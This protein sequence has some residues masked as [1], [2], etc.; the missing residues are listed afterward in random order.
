M[1]TKHC[2]SPTGAGERLGNQWIDIDTVGAE[3]AA[4]VLPRRESSSAQEVGEQ[5]CIG[6]VPRGQSEVGIGCVFSN[7]KISVAGMEV[8]R[9][10]PDENHR[11]T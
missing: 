7:G 11:F 8:D 10:R 5:R 9:L 2:A 3:P 1:G 6:E 4:G